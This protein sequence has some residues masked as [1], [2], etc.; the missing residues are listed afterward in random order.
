MSV[1]S[2]LIATDVIVIWAVATM[3]QAAT[4]RS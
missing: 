4:S 1:M 2:S 3:G